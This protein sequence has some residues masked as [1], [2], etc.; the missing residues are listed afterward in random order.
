MVIN[1]WQSVLLLLSAI[2]M[3]LFCFLPFLSYEFESEIAVKNLLSLNPV[4]FIANLVIVAL[5]V[6]DIFL[7]KNLKQQIN[8]ALI[9]LILQIV[10]LVLSIAI[11]FITK[12][13][14][15]STWGCGFA[16]L[17][18]SIVLT[19]FGRKFM[20]KDRKLLSSYDRLR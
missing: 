3:A 15:E 11:F 1:R 17:F 14:I 18:P 5:L 10:S 13:E 19:Y 16:F 6:I 12:G 20:I 8:V 2:C 9:C 7:F 4:F